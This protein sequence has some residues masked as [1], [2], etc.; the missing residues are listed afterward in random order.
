M[1][2][3]KTDRRS[4]RTRHLL[5]TALVDIMLQKRYDEITVQVLSIARTWAARPSTRTTSTKTISW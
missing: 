1:K 2:N 3:T 5:S 4:Q